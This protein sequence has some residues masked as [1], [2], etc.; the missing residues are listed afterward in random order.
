MLNCL[1]LYHLPND[2]CTFI[3]IISLDFKNKPINYQG[4]QFL[5]P[6]NGYGCG[7]RYSTRCPHFF[8]FLSSQSQ[9]V[10]QQSLR[11]STTKSRIHLT[12]SHIWK[13]ALKNKLEI[14][15]SG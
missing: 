13:R 3:Y 14:L 2:I 6:F 4:Q 15:T 10:G 9:D 11:P 12:I 5:T 8:F 1:V 7:A